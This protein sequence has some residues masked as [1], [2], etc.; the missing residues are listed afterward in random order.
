[1]V[2]D[3]AVRVQ[4]HL[5]RVGR[6]AGVVTPVGVLHDHARA[7]VVVVDRAVGRQVV[8]QQE[9]TGQRRAG[10]RQ[11]AVGVVRGRRDEAHEAVRADP[12]RGVV[13]AVERE[14][15]AQVERALVRVVGQGHRG[16][17]AGDVDPVEGRAAGLVAVGPAVAEGV[18]AARTVDAGA[19]VGLA[20]G[21]LDVLVLLHGPAGGL[22]GHVVGRGR[23]RE[24]EHAQAG[25]GHRQG[26]R[27]GAA[28]RQRGRQR[29]GVHGHGRRRQ[30]R[31]GGAVRQP[32]V[33][34]VL[35]LRADGEV[36]G[37]AGGQAVH[38]HGLGR[39]VHG[40]IGLA[41]HLRGGVPAGLVHDGS[42]RVADV[43]AAGRADDVVIARGRPVQLQPVGGRG[44]DGQVDDRAGRRLVR[45]ADQAQQVQAAAGHAQAAEGGDRV[46]ADV[47]QQRLAVRHGDA[48]EA[49]AQHGHGARDVRGGHRGAG[50]VVVAAGDRRHDVEARGRDVDGGGAVAGGPPA[51]LDHALVAV[52]RRHDGDHV[53]AVVVAGVVGRHVVVAA[54]VAGRGDEEDV[55][56]VGRHDGV[57]QGLA[58]AAAAPR[59][60]HDVDAH[61]RR[62]LD[63]RHGVVRRARAAGREELQAHDLDVPVHA[64]H[65]DAVVADAAD[66]A[67]AVRAVVVVVHGVVV[68]VR[69]VPAVDVVDEAVGVIV[70]AVAGDLARV[71]P[72]VGR[73]VGVR[74]VDAGV[75]D[76]DDH[77]GGTGEDVPRLDGVDVGVHRAGGAAPVSLAGVVHAPE[78]AEHRVV[79]GLVGVE[80][81]VRLRV[82]DVG[83]G[84]EG[85]HRL[86]DGLVADLPVLGAD[87]AEVLDLLARH[88]QCLLGRGDSRLELHD[89]FAGHPLLRQVDRSAGSRGEQAC[90]GNGHEQER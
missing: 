3:R 43:V 41:G 29:G 78:L 71:R 7:V 5:H 23:D 88:Q 55:G 8:P 76:R 87:E 9:R 50:E 14:V 51:G 62:V 79:R 46:V 28:G 81:I 2:L 60:A 61:H 32:A 26:L 90:H 13:H 1:M 53:R 56:R 85:R 30:R 33:V 48:G 75:D 44:A 38:L 83:V 47:H 6:T 57:Q 77:A 31:A 18:R 10:G 19:Q 4:V 59:V 11:G 34:A 70:D 22:G 45:V 74:V 89:E 68:V 65:A 27:L 58:E 16:A 82:L 86:H 67:G 40:G 84:L 35:V 72:G 15:E 80:D 42:G 24:V 25:I 12:E 64:R 39:A 63:A 73:Q 36:V 52:V 37:G 17:E 69:E 66:G 21:Q 20:L 54:A 49:P